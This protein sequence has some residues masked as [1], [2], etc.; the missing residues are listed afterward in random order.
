MPI[1][2]GVA[3]SVN[4]E[5]EFLGERS[6]Q[7]LDSGPPA[8]IVDIDGTLILNGEANQRLL[9]Y[10]DSFDDTEIIIVTAR[11]SNDRDDTLRELDSLDIDFDQLIM[12]PDADTASAGFKGEVAA[13][14]LEDF[15]VM[16]AIDNDPDNREVYRGLGITALDVDDVPDVGERSALDLTPPAWV[17]AIARSAADATPEI[18]AVT[19][20]AMTPAMWVE[21]REMLADSGNIVWGVV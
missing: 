10:L 18:L 13:S 20:N 2:Q 8:I 9:T 12:K 15:N 1:D 11:L 3:I 21:A 6:E 4:E 5:P 7:R 16:V 19:N 17:R 14:L